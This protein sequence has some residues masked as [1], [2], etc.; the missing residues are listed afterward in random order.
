MPVYLSVDAPPLLPRVPAGSHCRRTQSPS[1][2]R[3]I[4]VCQ[5]I[6]DRRVRGRCYGNRELETG[7]LELHF[8]FVERKAACGIGEDMVKD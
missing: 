2:R 5:L 7:L 4:C 6:I 8:H 3:L 1:P